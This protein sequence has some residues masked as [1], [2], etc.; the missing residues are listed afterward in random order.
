MAGIL[1]CSFRRQPSTNLIAMTNSVS[2]EERTACPATQDPE[3][4]GYTLPP[5]PKLNLGC[6]P[7]QPT[8]WVNIDGSNRAR[9]A[10]R[11]APV[12]RLLVRLGLL[13]PTEFGPHIKICDLNKPLPYATGTVAAIYAGEVWEHFELEQAERLTRECFRILKPEGVLRVCV[14]DG[15]EFWRRY[16]DLFDREMAK[17]ENERS[18][19]SLRKHVAMY[20]GDICTRKIWLGS[21][22]HTHKWQFD[23]VQLVQLFK[24]CGFS[25]AQR[26]PYHKSR[27]PDIETLERSDFLIVEAVKPANSSHPTAAISR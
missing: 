23:E 1:G 22:G 7:V 15:V 25:P 16:L 5:G 26:M 24:S 13:A 20:F 17:P 4:A 19:D 11:L 9:L 6:G 8:G 12:D 27:L 14:P 18:A 21:M 2:L 10:S 3:T